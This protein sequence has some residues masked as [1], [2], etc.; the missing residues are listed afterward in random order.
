MNYELNEYRVPRREILGLSDRACP[1]SFNPD[2]YIVYATV[3]CRSAEMN[4][5]TVH[6]KCSRNELLSSTSVLPD[7]SNSFHLDGRVVVRGWSGGGR[8]LHWLLLL[9]CFRFVAFLIVGFLPLGRLSFP[10]FHRSTKAFR[11]ILENQR[12]LVIAD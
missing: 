9:F 6:C 4:Y 2:L 12:R 7:L 8:I 10:T 5:S 3:H 11:F 1:A